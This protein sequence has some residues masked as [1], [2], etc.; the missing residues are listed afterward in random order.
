MNVALSAIILFILLIPGIALYAGLFTGNFSKPGPKLSLLE[1]LFSTG[2]FSLL[3]HCIALL[4]IRDTIRFDI[5]IKLIGGDI[6]DLDKMVPNHEFKRLILWFALYNL[7][8]DVICFII[9]K[10]LRILIQHLQ[11]D[12]KVPLLRVHNRWW[13]LL[14]GYYLDELGRPGDRKV[15]DLVLVDALVNTGAGAMLYTGYLVD[16]VCDGEDLQ[17]IYLQTP[18]RRTLVAKDTDSRAGTAAPGDAYSLKGDLLCLFYKDIQN[19]SVHFII[20]PEEDVASLEQAGE[21]ASEG[22][23]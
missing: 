20:A 14:N 16:F 4:L 22:D 7:I 9:G 13:Y 11:W 15:Y 5:L 18:L 19:I 12:V 17:R 1:G 2:L 21:M 8:L 3:V 10:L 23:V 6:K